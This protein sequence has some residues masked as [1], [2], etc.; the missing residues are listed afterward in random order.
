[1]NEK[2]YTPKELCKHFNV[3]S[4][5]LR[6]WSISGKIRCIKTK[7]G[8]R[9]YIIPEDQEHEKQ[10]IIYAR[11]SSNTQKYDL[12]RQVAF[13]QSKYPKHQVLTDIGSGLNFKRRNFRAILESLF[14]GNVA[15]V[16]V[17]HKDRF[18]RF[19]FDLFQFIFERHG[20]L[21]KVVEHD[22]FKEPAQELTDDILSIVTIFTARYYG[23][24]GYT[25]RLQKNKNL[26]ESGTDQTIRKMS[27]DDSL[28]LQQSQRVRK[29][30]HR[31]YKGIKVR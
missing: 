19:G 9:R 3:T 10:Y 18:A 1:M 7:G 26:S 12:E 15:E 24:R 2:H 31:N 27:W 25:L 13:L 16:V 4:E 30:K 17:A 8:H 5:T 22:E 6:L 14:N 11:V 20:S 23:Q 29:T 28:L 21:L